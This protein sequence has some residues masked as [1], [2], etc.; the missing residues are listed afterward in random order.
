MIQ[1]LTKETSLSCYHCGEDC[2][3]SNIVLEEKHF[4][5][6][7]CKTVYQLLKENDLCT[8]YDL[9]DSP[10]FA[11]R[12]GKLEKD[13]VWLNEDEIREQFITYEDEEK[14]VVNFSLP[15]IH[16]SSCIWLLENLYK[17]HTAILSSRVHFLKRTI[18]VTIARGDMEISQLAALLKKLGYPPKIDLERKKNGS[19]S[20]D[21]LILRLGIAGFCF[22]NIML[23][24]FP[25]YL[26]LEGVGAQFSS[27]FS[28]TSLVLSIPVMVIAYKEYFQNAILG[29][30][31]RLLNLDIPISI[32]VLALFGES[33][34]EI[35]S[36]TGEGYLDSLSGLV[37]FLLIGKWFQQKT[38]HRLSFDRTYNSYFP[39]SVLVE[40]GK[41]ISRKAV[42]R[43]EV[44]EIIRIRKDEIIPADAVLLSEKAEIDYSFVTGESEPSQK[45]TGALIYAGGRQKGTM[46]RLKIQ[47]KVS[48][49]Y[50]TQLW[51]QQGKKD[52]KT[53]TSIAD[54]AA[55]WFTPFI[56]LIALGALVVWMDAGLAKAVQIFTAVLIVA[57]PCGLAL[58][59]PFV[60]GH[61]I[62]WMG[63][64]G[65]FVKNIEVLDRLST[66]D[67]IIFDKTGTLSFSRKSDIG[68]SG[69][70]LSALKLKKISAVC[71]HSQ[72]PVSECIH[73]QIGDHHLPEVSDWKEVSGKGIAGKVDGSEIFIGNQS[74][75]D[76]NDCKGLENH[77]AQLANKTYV[78]IDGQIR[79]YY[80]F[81]SSFRPDWQKVIGGLKQKFKLS[82][83]S[84]DSDK[85][86]ETLIPVFP[87]NA[88]LKFFQSPF[89]KQNE[90]KRL[91]EMG[92]KVLMVG[93]GLND[94][95][96]LMQSDVGVAV[97]E[98]INN[99]S[100]ACDIIMDSQLFSKLN[101]IINFNRNCRRLIYYGYGLSFSYNVIG[102]AFAVQGYLTPLIA[103]VLMPLSSLSVILFTSIST[104]YMGR[105]IDHIHK[106][107]FYH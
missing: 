72:H 98:E 89:D 45:E 91:Q 25:E 71:S 19:S 99:F 8:Y 92:E 21:H 60:F 4:C 18:T 61:A 1:D 35:F 66:I 83:L 51:E 16:C 44:G 5:C 47:K 23:L 96:A 40:D 38:Y 43:L 95:G 97:S 63:K 56:L 7:G 31:H 41:I 68:Y 46:I 69:E 39:V 55:K 34:F 3:D 80:F 73:H 84:G 101:T 62:R 2:L 30:K 70:R 52:H 100:P 90:V 64:W 105:K 26:S 24:S 14:I 20:S 79:G 9:N 85:D 76:A 11:Q 13:Y 87:P 12:T 75:M 33:V 82:M 67:H 22:G 29:L 27:I 106:S 28:L 48:Q 104:Y 93:D 86:R 107:D 49:S 78:A 94:A 102:L 103:A 17:L 36:Q 57:C 77:Q 65:F 42:K 53:H 10:G 58:T 81:S 6:Q 54:N 37:F 59:A 32:G 88:T 50:L 74:W 15:Q